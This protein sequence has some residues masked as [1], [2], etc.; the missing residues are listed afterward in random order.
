[1]LNDQLPIKYRMWPGRVLPAEGGIYFPLKIFWI[2]ADAG[3]TP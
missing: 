3:M 1:M 2:P